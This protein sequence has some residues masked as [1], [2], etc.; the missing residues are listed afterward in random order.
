LTQNGQLTL[1]FFLKKISLWIVIKV[2][3]KSSLFN[4]RIIHTDGLKRNIWYWYNYILK[5]K[6]NFDIMGITWTLNC[7][8]KN[9]SVFCHCSPVHC[10]K[11]TRKGRVSSSC[12]QTAFCLYLSV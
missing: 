5:S 3:N 6:P 12:T 9:Q 8:L 2:S 10:G 4:K 7:N 1:R 11:K